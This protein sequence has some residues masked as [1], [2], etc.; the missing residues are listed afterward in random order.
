MHASTQDDALLKKWRK[1]SEI[2]A[3]FLN[4]CGEHVS[5]EEWRDFLHKYQ[6]NAFEWIQSVD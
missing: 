5:W 2:I 6:A 3:A 4:E 1:R